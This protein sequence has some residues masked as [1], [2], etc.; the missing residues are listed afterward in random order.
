MGG[1]MTKEQKK[2]FIAEIKVEL[3]D[4]INS[5]CNHFVS[6]SEKKLMTKIDINDRKLNKAFQETIDKFEEEM[7]KTAEYTKK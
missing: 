1:E 5:I 2:A 4:M 7:L 6:D 3:R